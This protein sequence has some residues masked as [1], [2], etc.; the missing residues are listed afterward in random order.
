MPKT[1]AERLRDKF[2]RH[3]TDLR[4]NMAI[5]SNPNGVEGESVIGVLRRVFLVKYPMLQRRYDW[6][7]AKRSTNEDLGSRYSRFKQAGVEANL[8]DVTRDELMILCIV[9]NL[10][11]RTLASRILRSEDDSL[12]AAE[13]II[14]AAQVANNT[15]AAEQ[16]IATAA[17]VTSPSKGK[18]RGKSGCPTCTGILRPYG[19][20]P[21]D[22]PAKTMNC[23]KCK[24]LGHIRPSCPNRGPRP[25]ASQPKA[26][27]PTASP[28]A[29]AQED[30]EDKDDVATVS[31]VH[32]T[33]GPQPPFYPSHL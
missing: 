28:A 27:P 15:T 2:T 12:Q 11:D 9:V 14:V 33:P 32:A 4:P 29:T 5:F 3:N 16:P 17:A 8:H 19:H 31:R 13:R 10:G 7:S 1:A 18:G 21:A 24:V 30:C 23:N 6:L 25:K 20:A 22:C 26:K